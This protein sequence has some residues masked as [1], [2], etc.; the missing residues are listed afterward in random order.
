[1]QL[2]ADEKL[3]H[4]H[5]VYRVSDDLAAAPSLELIIRDINDVLPKDEVI[6]FPGRVSE[7]AA[8]EGAS[9][10]RPI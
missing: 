3:D 9:V 4:A 2:P 7:Q 8:S 10:S 1:M 5:A 6:V